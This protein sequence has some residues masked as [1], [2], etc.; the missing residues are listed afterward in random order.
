MFP[1]MDVYVTEQNKSQEIAAFALWLS[2]RNGQ[3]YFCRYTENVLKI[4]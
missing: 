4:I 3:R 2:R 1:Q